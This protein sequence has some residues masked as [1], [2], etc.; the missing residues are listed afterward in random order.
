VGALSRNGRRARIERALVVAIALHSAVIG[1]VAIFATA[2]ASRFA[3]FDDVR[4]L[5]FPRQVGV[6]HIV[7]AMAYAIE[8]FRHRDV[9]ILLATKAIAVSFLGGS[10]LAGSLPW[11]VPLAATGDAAMA[12]AVLLAHRAAERERS[13][14]A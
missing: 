7:V 1:L 11:V 2:A 10:L 8:Y 5:F 14:A 4:P 9:T 13:E 12:V 3:G 6:F